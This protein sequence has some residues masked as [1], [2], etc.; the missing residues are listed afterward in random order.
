MYAP[1]CSRVAAVEALHPSDVTSYAVD[2]CVRRRSRRAAAAGRR[3]S[4]QTITITLTFA[5]SIDGAAYQTS[6]GVYAGVYQDLANAVST[7]TAALETACGCTL[8]VD[9]V[10]IDLATRWVD[11][12]MDL[13]R[14]DEEYDQGEYYAGADCPNGCSGHGSCS[15]N[16]CVCHA[17]WG[18]GDGTGGACDQRKCPYS[19]AW[20]DTPSSENKAHALRECGGRGLCDRDTG[21]C[22][23]S[24]VKQ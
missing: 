2:G 3:L 4:T 23:V 15:T 6:S 5:T 22:Q 7:M 14:G 20:V 11:P 24:L 19:S 8:T 10:S 13:N 9:S 12:N 17:N 1:L 21:D 16:G 18:S